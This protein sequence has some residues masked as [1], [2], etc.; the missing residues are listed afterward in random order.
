MLNQFFKL[1]QNN[2]SISQEILAGFSTFLTMSFIIAVNPSILSEAGI[3]FASG[4]VATLL[5]TILGTLIMGLY[6]RWPVAVAP[7]MG[8][9]AY[10]AFVVV[11]GYGLS[12][13]QALA[14]VF[15]SSVAF[16]I[17]SISRI[18]S[19]LILSIPAEMQIAITAGIG[20]FLAMIGLQASGLVV[21]NPDTLVGLGPL[22]K[23][24]TAFGLAGLI[25]MAGLEKMGVKGGILIT[26]LGLSLIGW[27]T[28]LSGFNGIAGLP[29]MASAAFSLDF[30]A[31]TTTAFL[32]VVFVMFFV[33]FFDT[34]G[35]LTAIAEP[36][37]LKNKKGE[38]KNL[39]KAVLADTSASIFGSLLGTSN[40]TTYLESAAGLKSGGR[41]G[42]VAVTIAALFAACLFLEPLF[43]SIPAFATAP[44]LIYVSIGFMGGLRHIDWSDISVA[45]P[46]L[47]TIFLMPLTFSI[48]AGI[49]VGFLSY[50]L[51]KLM[52]RKGR[53][54][55]PAIFVLTGFGLIWIFLQ[56]AF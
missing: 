27:L 11:L 54:I 49:S 39:D 24:E 4:F 37:H 55:P 43:S 19:W 31:L 10:F 42:L 44:A 9:N 21:D 14:A 25:V 47:L 52:T 56:Y 7:G 5:A 48:A 13:Q 38:I 26:I 1:S 40:M 20:L 50:T 8:L 16:F 2:T 22:N 53:E 32:S 29:P 34:T 45:L 41:T 35:T 51:I 33:D 23:P 28:G 46:V 3:D 12:W 6:A 18:R 17:F 30:S 36:A 15:I